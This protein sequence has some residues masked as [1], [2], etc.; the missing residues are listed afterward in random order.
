MFGR[1][2]FCFVSKNIR[3]TLGIMDGL[4]FRTFYVKKLE[5]WEDKKIYQKVRAY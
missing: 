4:P 1:G 2:R 3:S 5:I